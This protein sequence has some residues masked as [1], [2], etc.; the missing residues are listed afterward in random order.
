MSS[1]I[2]T[3]RP[4]TF[5]LSAA[6]AATL[7]AALKALGGKDSNALIARL[8]TAIFQALPALEELIKTSEAQVNAEITP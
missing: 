1:R 3:S 4:I 5:A 6:E 2:L 8:D 7:W